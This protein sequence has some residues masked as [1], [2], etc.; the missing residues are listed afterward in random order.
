MTAFNMSLD[1]SK[2]I[3]LDMSPSDISRPDVWRAALV[4]PVQGSS[5]AAKS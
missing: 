5:V 3:S 4:A 2:D 1:M